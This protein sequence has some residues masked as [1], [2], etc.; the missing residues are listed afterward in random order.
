MEQNNWL[1]GYKSSRVQGIKG[2]S[3]QYTA[4]RY[5]ID[6]DGSFQR[7]FLMTNYPID[8][9]GKISEDNLLLK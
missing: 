1:N 2:A 5:A 6:T 8:F 3:N 7:L 9:N 4:A